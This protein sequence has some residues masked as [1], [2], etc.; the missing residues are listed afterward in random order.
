M[1]Q[2][3]DCDLQLLKEVERLR[4][5]VAKYEI[6]SDASDLGGPSHA[7]T[8]EMRYFESMLVVM[9]LY[10][11]SWI[12]CRGRIEYFDGDPVPDGLE[13]GEGTLQY[14]NGD[15]YDVHGS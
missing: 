2:D 6:T 14:S 9:S 10:V 8:Y 13:L 5:E 3:S 15:S 7:D 11:M 12:C 1:S 4:A